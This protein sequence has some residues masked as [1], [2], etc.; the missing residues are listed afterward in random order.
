MLKTLFIMNMK[1]HIAV[2]KKAHV[3]KIEGTDLYQLL[4]WISFSADSVPFLLNYEVGY[5]A[6]APG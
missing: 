2:I 3:R 6:T 1:K 5:Y 4:I